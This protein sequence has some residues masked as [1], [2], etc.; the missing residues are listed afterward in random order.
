MTFG[1]NLRQKSSM[2]KNKST[3]QYV[4]QTVQ[5]LQNTRLFCTAENMALHMPHKDQHT[6]F[7]LVQKNYHCQ[8]PEVMPAHFW[9]ALEGSF[10]G[11]KDLQPA[12]C[13]FSKGIITNPPV[14]PLFPGF[15]VRTLIFSI[16]PKRSIVKCWENA[17][18]GSH[19][20]Q[21]PSCQMQTSFYLKVNQ[22]FTSSK[23]FLNFKVFR[24]MQALQPQNL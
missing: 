20:A 11:K 18:E 21:N 19:P 10:P 4:L 17:A 12:H 15:P 13:T 5:C 2:I 22:T 3:C 23:V 16:F 1:D 24:V 7:M 9:A 14:V 8:N 6:F